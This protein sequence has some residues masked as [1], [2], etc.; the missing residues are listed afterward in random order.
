[1]GIPIVALFLQTPLAWTAGEGA[2]AAG[3]LAL[4]AMTDGLISNPTVVATFAVNPQSIPANQFPDVDVA[5]LPGADLYCATWVEHNDSPESGRTTAARLV[6]SDGTPTGSKLFPHGALVYSDRPKVAAVAGVRRFAV[7]AIGGLEVSEAP[8]VSAI[9]EF[10]NVYEPPSLFVGPD[11]ESIDLGGE[12]TAIADDFLLAYSDY[13][14]I[15]LVQIDVLTLEIVATLALTP[16]SNDRAVAISK[17]G[18]LP[19]RYLVVWR[20]GTGSAGDVFGAIV[21]RD[22]DVLVPPFAIAATSAQEDAPEVD[23]DGTH[24]AV[25]FERVNASGD[26]DI[27]C[28]GVSYDAQ[29]GTVTLG[30][31]RTIEGD[32]GQ[33][34]REPTVAWMGESYLV[35]FIEQFSGSDWDVFVRSVDSITCANCEGESVVFN[36]VTNEEAVALAS[37]RAAGDPGDEALITWVTRT[38]QTSPQYGA[39]FVVGNVQDRL[40]RADDGVVVDLG[41]GCGAG[42]VASATCASS[43]ETARFGLRLEAAAPSTRA[44]LALGVAPLGV[45]CG[46]CRSIADPFRLIV[47]RTDASGA[48]SVSL[49]LPPS[50]SLPG[51]KFLAQWLVDAPNGCSALDAKPG[52]VHSVSNA[53]EITVQ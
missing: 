40:F 31:E 15:S 4:P 34:E 47:A 8:R 19:G 7:A 52:F 45:G 37:Q 30:A 16:A 36:P 23:G 25:A 46:P 24:W 38:S 48:A 22:L 11:S 33:E 41:G 6:A 21:S 3:Q 39:P 13:A 32:V 50:V 10:G 49:P 9:D 43:A 14:S 27:V 26:G 53:L 20:R 44:F 2:K 29:N 12:A 18:G 28:R 17:T 35:G 51:T 42:G 1:M 5:Y